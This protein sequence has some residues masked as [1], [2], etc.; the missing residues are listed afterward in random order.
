M[1]RITGNRVCLLSNATHPYYIAFSSPSFCPEWIVPSKPEKRQCVFNDGVGRY[2]DPVSGEAYCS[3]KCGRRLKENREKEFSIVIPYQDEKNATVKVTPSVKSELNPPIQ[4]TQTTLPPS[5]PSKSPNLPVK[6]KQPPLPK[7]TPKIQPQ[8]S[9]SQQ[10]QSQQSQQPQ[11]P[12]SQQSQL[13]QP[14]QPQQQPQSQQP[15]QSQPQTMIVSTTNSQGQIVRY[16]LNLTKPVYIN[17]QAVTVPVNQNQ[18]YYLQTASTTGE[19]SVQPHLMTGTSRMNDGNVYYCM[20]P[21]IPLISPP[22]Q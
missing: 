7:I 11:Q 10:S 6:P 18:V 14:P 4:S 21:M 19:K 12:Q 5:L 13:Q 16:Q 1:N 22:I 15:P 17:S 20:V 2:I 8:Q 9:Q 3:L